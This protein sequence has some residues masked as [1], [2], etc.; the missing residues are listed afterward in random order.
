MYYFEMQNQAIKLN[1]ETAA[2]P[3]LNRAIAENIF[4]GCV[5]GVGIDSDQPFLKAYGAY[6]NAYP[7]RIDS[8]FDIASVT[9]SIPVGTLALKWV[10]EGKLNLHQKVFEVLTEYKV[11]HK[12]SVEVWHLLTH[13]LDY[14]FPMS[15][16]KDLTPEEIWDKLMRHA[17]REQPGSSFS[18]GNAAS[19]ILGGF[20]ERMS[21][22][23]LDSLARD[24][25]F[26]PLGMR[27]TGWNP[28]TRHSR[29]RIVPTEECSW[30]NRVI[31]GE[32]HDE[33]A[34][35][36][37]KPVGSAGVFSTVPD[38]LR[39]SQMVLQDGISC[40][41]QRV[42][43]VGLLELVTRNALP[44]VNGQGTALGW[45]LFNPKFMGSI[46]SNRT[47]GKTGFT[48][49]SVVCDPER[50]MSV[51]LFS[52]FTWPKREST[53]ERIYETRRRLHDA[54]FALV[55]VKD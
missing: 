29:E 9:K 45:E 6:G 39:F 3:I 25:L 15:T 8:V 22:K 20:L 17:F 1:L 49:A 2:D 47:F 7:M 30:R 19:L 48:G 35:A 33:S 13:S 14:R 55:P 32:V 27:D 26:L 38:L 31:C 37:G 11:S 46:V 51:V 28:L 43:P 18:Y 12:E 23:S 36:M 42:I 34:F 21:G 24:E 50:N 10:L 40:E 5:L 4:S 53:V 44:H 41:G 52:N 16:L 54:L